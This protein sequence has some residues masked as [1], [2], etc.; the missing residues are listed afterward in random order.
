VADV[1]SSRSDTGSDIGRWDVD[2]LKAGAGV[3]LLFAVPF[4]VLAAVVSSDSGGVNAVFFFGALAGF[5]LGAGCAAW[6]QRRGTPLTHGIITAV[7]T[8][9]AAQAAFIVIRVVS[10]REVNWMGAAFTLSLVLLAGLI[11]GVLG[12]RLQAKGFE[13]RRHPSSDRRPT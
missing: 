2:A 11:G 13:P 6:I 8:Y 1:M 7:G 9:L 5:V 3:S 4:T 10:G 12:R